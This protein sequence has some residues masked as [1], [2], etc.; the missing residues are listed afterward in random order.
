MGHGARFA[1]VASVLLAGCVTTPPA[2][3]V[4]PGS[5]DYLALLARFPSPNAAVGPD[6]HGPEGEQPMT[7][8]LV[9]GAEALRL[10][11]HPAASS[12]RFATSAWALV[13]GSDADAS[14]IR[15]W[16]LPFAWDFFGD[17]VLTRPGAAMAVYSGIAIQGLLD[18][19]PILPETAGALPARAD[20]AEAVAST[21]TGFAR[22]AFTAGNGTGWFWYSEIPEDATFVANAASYLAG[23]CRRALAETPGSFAPADAALVEDRVDA[24]VRHVLA[25][26]RDGRPSWSYD[27][28]RPHEPNDIVHQAY[29]VHGLE[30]YRASGGRVPLPWDRATLTGT[31]APFWVGGDLREYSPE[32]GADVPATL[33]DRPARLWGVGM[34]LGTQACWGKSADAERLVAEL[35]ARYGPWPNLT[36][37]PRSYAE[38]GAFYG[39]HSA[40]V[41]WGL[42]ALE[43]APG[44]CAVRK[45]I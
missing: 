23:S 32:D 3:V 15:G 22:S 26:S 42:A 41:L 45:G 12:E 11:A 9:L 29:I 7:H 10:R 16:G 24:T 44:T 18:A 39:R 17:G 38:D 1:L 40:H 4:A 14:G 30:T 31:L 37:Y 2:A 6:S 19:I 5:E 36:L 43:F 28:P 27:A 25:T 21:C 35:K 13:N 34:A 8:G 20:A 33:V